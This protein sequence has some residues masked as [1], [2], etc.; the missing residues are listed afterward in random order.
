[1]GLLRIINPFRPQ[2]L[3]PLKVAC[4][5]RLRAHQGNQIGT[6]HGSHAGHL[7][8]KGYPKDWIDKR[9]RGIA[10]RHTLTR[11]W[12]ERGAQSDI[13]YAILTND[14]ME[15]TFGLKVEDYKNLKGLRRENLRDHMDDIELIL[16]MLGEATTTRLTQD[17]NST[18]FSKLRVDA[19]DG[20]DVAGAARKD[21][22]KRSGRSVVSKRNYLG[23]KKRKQLN[24]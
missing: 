14:I 8:E 23:L 17:R 2:R 12:S 21:I 9:V 22:E 1:M 24:K 16:T 6:C 18:G 5:G 19:K 11:E 7:R 15:G 3:N 4:Q 10:V 20:G 13:E